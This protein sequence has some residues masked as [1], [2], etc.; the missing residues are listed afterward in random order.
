MVFVN[1]KE[2]Q[3]VQGLRKVFDSFFESSSFLAFTV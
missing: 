2:Q 1:G 3:S